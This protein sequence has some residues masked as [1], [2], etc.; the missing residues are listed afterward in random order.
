MTNKI[1]PEERMIILAD[2]VNRYFSG[3]TA[4]FFGMDYSGQREMRRFFDALYKLNMSFRL[5]YSDL[6]MR[7]SLDPIFNEYRELV[8]E[9]PKG[10]QIYKGL[11]LPDAYVGVEN[12]AL[13]SHTGRSAISGPID[14]LFGMHEDVIPGKGHTMVYLMTTEGDDIGVSNFAAVRLFDKFIGV[15]GHMERL[16]PTALAMLE[17]YDMVRQLSRREPESIIESPSGSTDNPLFKVLDDVTS[18]R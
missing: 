13:S 15:S 9:G 1:P 10:L 18:T 11:A 6:E 16:T 12:N 2:E 4:H 5:S 8:R 3:K 7:S 17:E 14:L